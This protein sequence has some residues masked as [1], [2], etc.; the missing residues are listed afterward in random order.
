MYCIDTSA[1]IHAWRRD[2]PPDVFQSLWDQLDRLI[3]QGRLF[4]SIEVLLEL[5]RGGD[6]I[7]QWA[8]QR[9]HAFLDADAT[10][11][12]V[13]ATIVDSFPSFLPSDSPDGIWADP[14]I[15]A[16]AK[17]NGWAVV[18][19]EKAV[20]PGAKRI[21]I[22]N[23]CQEVGV[24]CTEFLQLIRREGWRFGALL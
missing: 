14:Y 7:Y 13:V 10:V 18:T 15:V 23:V 12:R 24:E 9:E 5:K 1:L 8:K 20:S 2:Y 22:P 16:I 3:K 6:E 4:S 11:Q 21:K 19:G 17:V